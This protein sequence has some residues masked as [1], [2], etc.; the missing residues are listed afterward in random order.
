MTPSANWNGS[1][2]TTVTVTDQDNQS[3]Q[4]QLAIRV[5]PVNDKPVIS[6]IPQQS[7]L[8]GLH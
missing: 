6:D 3:D 1:R 2:T 5:N 4:T 8:Q 7:L